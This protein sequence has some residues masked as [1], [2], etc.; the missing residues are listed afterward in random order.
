MKRLVSLIL[1]LILAGACAGCGETPQPGTEATVT[2]ADTLNLHLGAEP[3]SIDPAYATSGGGGSYAV[4]LFEGLT[5]LDKHLQ[6]IGGMAEDWTVGEN[7]EGLPLYTFTIRE[8]ALWSDGRPVR[9]QDFVF[10]WQRAVD[11]ATEADSAYLLYPI[12]NARQILEGVTTEKEDGSTQTEYLEPTELGVYAVDDQTLEVTLEGPCP[13]FLEL[14]T[15]PIFY[16]VR[17]D[18]VTQSPLGWTN[19]AET[20]L[21]NGPYMFK[22]WNHDRSLSMVVNDGYW[23]FDP[24]SPLGLHF[25]LS[26]DDAAVYEDFSQ[27]RLLMASTFP[28]LERDAL[29]QTGTLTQVPRLGAYYYAFRTGETAQEALQDPNVRKAISLAVDREAIAATGNFG[30]V[31]AAGLVP[32]GVPGPGRG[33]DFRKTGKAYFSGH[34]QD[35]ARAKDLL[36]AAGYPGGAGFPT[37]TFLTNDTPGHVEIAEAV[38]RM[39]QEGLGITMEVKALGWDDFEAARAGEDWDLVRGGAL[40]Q[41]RD[42]Y[43]FLDTFVTDGPRNDGGFSNEDYDKAVGD[44]MTAETQ[45]ERLQ[46]LHQ[47]EDLLVDEQAAVLPITYY[48]QDRLTQDTLRGVVDHAAGYAYFRW[49]SAGA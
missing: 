25:V 40:G 4:Q 24:T 10:A 16:P 17:E 35:L 18:T 23:D 47:A 8:G 26:D 15:L 49:A 46:L 29:T 45:A 7:E 27:G 48:S 12:R 6:V 20:C 38:A 36:A 22:E 39:L 43:A 32:Y 5:T 44:S 1:A 30:R 41:V 13:Y 14:L 31:A 9:A 33:E 42:A 19:T 3:A 2:Q 11:P 28:P 37:I 34:E 21:T